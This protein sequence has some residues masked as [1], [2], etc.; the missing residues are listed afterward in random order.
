M[1]NSELRRW[2]ALALAP[3]LA[4]SA[5]HSEAA[6]TADDILLNFEEPVDGRDYVAIGNVRGWSWARCGVDHIELTI[7]EALYGNVPSGG[8]RFDVPA[9]YPEQDYPGSADS[10]FSMAYNYGNLTPGRHSMEIRVYDT[11]GNVA[12]RKNTFTTNRFGQKMTKDLGSVD[13]TGATFTTKKT[14]VNVSG[15]ILNDGAYDFELNWRNAAQG[16]AIENVSGRGSVEF[17]SQTERSPGGAGVRSLAGAGP[18]TANAWPATAS[19]T[20]Q[21][22]GIVLN[23]EEPVI[24]NGY[25]SISNIRGWAVSPHGMDRI[26]LYMDGE[27]FGNIPMGGTRYDVSL[28]YPS[29]QFPGS[30]E[31][32]FAMAYNYANLAAGEHTFSVRAYDKSGYVAEA[33]STFDVSSF[34][35]S[36]LKG[37]N[38]L[39]VAGADVEASNNIITIKD[40]LVQLDP[41]RSGLQVAADDGRFNTLLEFD[42]PSQSFKISNV[43]QSQNYWETGLWGACLGEC[44]LLAGHRERSVICRDAQGVAVSAG[45]C[46]RPAPRATAV[47]TA[48]DEYVWRLAAWGACEG[49]CGRGVGAQTRRVECVSDDL[50]VVD[51]A[52]CGSDKPDE[53]QKCTVCDLYTWYESPW[54]P[55]Q[56]DCGE[57]SGIQERQV[58]CQDSSGRRADDA[59]CEGDKPVTTQSCTACVAYTWFTGAWGACQGE[60]GVGNGVQERQVLCRDSSGGEVDDANCEDVKPVTRRSCTASYCEVPL[61]YAWRVGDW[62][63]CTGECGDG[64]G[65]QA[66][67]VACF[68]SANEPV[69]DSLCTEVK[70]ASAQACTASI[71]EVYVW[72]TG[73]WGV[74]T[75]ECGTDNATQTRAVECRSSQGVTVGDENCE[76]AK[77]AATQACTAS[78]CSTG[79]DE[80]PSSAFEINFSPIFR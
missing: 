51:D 8:K 70:P 42:V 69:D 20:V 55:C 47:C 72:Y 41:D 28:R 73:E 59:N 11:E 65:L 10:G 16:F 32:G 33:S 18:V 9:E 49:N 62:G 57:G 44:G 54:G 7:D 6:C 68:S 63:A 53:T 30:R 14:G 26:E 38:L 24:G 67:S 34:N 39:N 45:D 25:A 61:T 64:N 17:G 37:E 71:C 40:I 43:N 60:C 76:E 31:S 2:A 78:E 77:P 27:L 1:R 13:V 50:T 79:N 36:Y 35:T 48:C 75:G 74:C 19:R 5:V 4:L 80:V 15:G 66:R 58:F 52:N 46:P 21:S 3:A 12:S 22:E 29:E 56:G 23:F